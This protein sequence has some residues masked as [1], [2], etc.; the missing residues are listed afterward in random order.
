M[1]SKTSD[2]QKLKSIL[3]DPLSFMQSQFELNPS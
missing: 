1:L 3:G 2:I